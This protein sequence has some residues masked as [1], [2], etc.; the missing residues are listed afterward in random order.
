MTAKSPFDLTLALGCARAGAK[1]DAYIDGVS[2]LG[3][4]LIF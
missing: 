2:K 4:G 3:T 1:L